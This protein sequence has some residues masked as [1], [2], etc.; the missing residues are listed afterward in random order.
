MVD[1]PILRLSACFLLLLVF[2]PSFDAQMYTST[3]NY[4][5]TQYY[6]TTRRTNSYSK[7]ADYDQVLHS[8]TIIA[9]M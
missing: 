7:F 5:S 3:P 9:S 6:A 4:W 8:V 1:S 2:L